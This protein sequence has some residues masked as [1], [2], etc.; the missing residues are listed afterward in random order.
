MPYTVKELKEYLEEQNV[1]DSAE[2]I[3]KFL[4]TSNCFKIS[5]MDFY[6]DQDEVHLEIDLAKR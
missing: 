6:K 3:I 4:Y 2:V 1:P 5:D